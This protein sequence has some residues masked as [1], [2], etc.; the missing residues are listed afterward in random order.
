MRRALV[1][2]LTTAAALAA[3]APASAAQNALD[4]GR[5]EIERASVLVDQSLDAA[6]AGDRD[7]AYKLARSAYLDHYEFVEIPMRLRDPNK[8]LD[9][10]FKFQKF[11]NDIR[12]GAS[13]GKIRRDVADVR[14]GLVAS[15]RVL[16]N[17]GVAA[18]A[19][20]FAFSFSILFREGIEAVLLIAILLGSLSA[21]SAQNYKRPLGWGVAAAVGATG[22]TWA[23]A[24]LVIDIAP[25]SR[26][27]LEAI[28]ALLAVVVLVVVSFWLVSRLEHRRRQEFMRA[29]LASA[30]A[31]GTTIA[32]VGLGFTAVY[33]EGFETVLFYQALSLF[34]QCLTLWVVLGA[35]A[36]AVGLGA[37]GY[38]ILKAGKQLPL[39]PMLVTG[40][41]ILLL[42]SVAFA[43]NAVRSLQSADLLQATPVSS[44]RLPVFLAEL[45]GIHPTREGLAI[46]AAMLLVFVLGA[47]YV[48][49]WQPARRRRREQRRET[50]ATA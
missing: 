16:A 15:D 39:K 41:S 5:A 13:V 33:R 36:A 12:D 24:T 43:G 9:T 10:E 7:K 47:A 3:A 29:R 1:A 35:V 28:T 6:K 38:A 49:A 2:L 45:T 18:P 34:A 23:L 11:R 27:V 48:F 8:V 22:L 46:Q 37:A 40:A 25:V 26:E 20:A 19:V 4:R 50:A 31:A 32:F 17:K 14:A 30:M 21:G 42:L 44:P